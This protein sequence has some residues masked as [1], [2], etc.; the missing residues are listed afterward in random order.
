MV[1]QLTEIMEA[2]ISLLISVSAIFLPP[3]FLNHGGTFLLSLDIFSLK[4]FWEVI[5]FTEKQV[6]L[7]P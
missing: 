7:K 3:L 4:G 2:A 6:R 1:S 5:D